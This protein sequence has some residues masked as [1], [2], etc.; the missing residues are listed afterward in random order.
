LQVFR[1][2]PARTEGIQRAI[3]GD[4]V[5]PGTDRRAF[6]ELLKAAPRGEQ[7]LLE[8]VLGVVRRADDPVGMQLEFLPVGV[9]QLAERILLAGPRTGEDL[10]GHGRILARTLPFTR[11]RSN[12]ASRARNSPRSFRRGTRLNKHTDSHHPRGPRRW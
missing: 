10:L 3:G 6:L 9:G 7:R 8:Q 5:Q 12:D 11:I 2:A 1:A 4:P